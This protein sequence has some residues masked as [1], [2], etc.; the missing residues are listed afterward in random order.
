MVEKIIL[1]NPKI[2]RYQA[3]LSRFLALIASLMAHIK[4]KLWLELNSCRIDQSQVF[5]RKIINTFFSFFHHNIKSQYILPLFGS[6]ELNI[7]WKCIIMHVLIQTDNFTVEV[8]T[9]T[10][11]KAKFYVKKR[12]CKESQNFM[13]LGYFEQTSCQN[14]I[15]DGSYE[16][17]NTC[18]NST[19]IGWIKIKSSFGIG[20][21]FFIFSSEYQILA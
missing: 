14:R 16:N 19:F 20:F 2:C 6:T 21:I 11:Y 8:F 4:P 10:S 3:I 1:K 7:L 5:I 18:Q 15:I 12:N 9:K 17:L 13:I